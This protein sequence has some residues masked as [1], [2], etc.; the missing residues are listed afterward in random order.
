MQEKPAARPALLLENITAMAT[1]RQKI[2][3]ETLTALVPML[4]LDE[5]IIVRE[6]VSR[7]HLRSLPAQ[8]AVWLCLI[9]YI[10][11]VHTDYDALLDE[12]YD[13]DSARHFVLDGI[14]DVLQGW[15][16]SR[17]LVMDDEALDVEIPVKSADQSAG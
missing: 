1:K 2:V 6:M 9:A 14:N 12:G 16:G 8:K 7:K 11:H 4:P 3:N 17:F 5:A 10:R 15:H 13:R